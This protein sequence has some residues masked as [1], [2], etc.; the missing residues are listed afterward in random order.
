LFSDQV[1]CNRQPATKSSQQLLI[2]K[3]KS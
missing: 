1:T 3:I 2:K